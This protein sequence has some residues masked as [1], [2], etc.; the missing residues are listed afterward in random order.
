MPG[1]TSRSGETSSCH[2]AGAHG[3]A[4]NQQHGNGKQPNEYVQDK[5][6]LAIESRL[7]KFLVPESDREADPC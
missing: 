2:A 7:Q 6:H 4:H 5:Q 3:T 1:L